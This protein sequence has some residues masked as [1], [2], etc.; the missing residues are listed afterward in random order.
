MSNLNQF[1]FDLS[2]SNR[3][4]TFFYGEY[5]PATKE[6]NFVNGGHNPP[7]I[8]RGEDRWWVCSARRYT[9]RARLR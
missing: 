5:N 7:M 4:A 2:P 1:L 8:L 3:Y 9:S 6:L